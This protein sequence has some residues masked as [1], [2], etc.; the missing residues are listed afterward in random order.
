[1]EC[2]VGLRGFASPT[3][4]VSAVPS[5]VTDIDG[6]HDLYAKKDD[7]GSGTAL[8]RS[9]VSL[10]PVETMSFIMMVGDEE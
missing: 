5:V 6:T 4:N 8:R 3:D 9:N 1:M 10:C 2:P 7:E